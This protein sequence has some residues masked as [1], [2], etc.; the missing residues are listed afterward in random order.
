MK[1]PTISY[2][3]NARELLMLIGHAT[4]RQAAA[5]LPSKGM[6]A[7]EKAPGT[8]ARLVLGG[9]PRRRVPTSFPA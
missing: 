1:G 3:V 8:F 4:D 9:K 5:A 2:R 7:V 6:A